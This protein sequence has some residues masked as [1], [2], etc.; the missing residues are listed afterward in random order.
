[1]AIK[2]LF[3]ASALSLLGL[4]STTAVTNSVGENQLRQSAEIPNSAVGQPNVSEIFA[5]AL[6]AAKTADRMQFTES[7]DRLQDTNAN[8]ADAAR[9][10]AM[11]FH[12]SIYE[13]SDLE[14]AVAR[15]RNWPASDRAS[16]NLEIAKLNAPTSRLG[17]FFGFDEPV[18]EPVTL[19]GRL[20][21]ADWLIENERFEEAR[22]IVTP[23][24]HRDRLS[25][26]LESEFPLRFE[27]I[28][29]EQDHQTRYLSMMARDRIRSGGRVAELAGYQGLHA[30]Y[31]A[32]I[33]NQTAADRLIA[34]LPEAQALSAPGILAMVEQ[35]RKQDEPAA[36]AE[37]AV[38]FTQ[39]EDFD[40]LN[41]TAW[42]N[43][44]RIVS[45]MLR[46]RGNV[47][48][49]FMIAELIPP[50]EPVEEVDAAFHAGWIAL[51]ELNDPQRALPH[52]EKILKVARGP[53][54]RSRGY[55]WLGRAYEEMGNQ[56]Q[57]Q[58]NYKSAVEHP[59]TFYGQAAASELDIS[60]VDALSVN[61][62][63]VD[64]AI[65]VRNPLVQAGLYLV[66]AGEERA[67]RVFFTDMAQFIQDPGLISALIAQLVERHQHFTALRLGKTALFEG[68]V[69]NAASH[70]V[71]VL[72][73]DANLSPRDLALTYAV[74]R[75]ESEFRVDARST[76]GAQGLLQL[77]PATAREV[78][79]SL[80]LP[81]STTRL[82]SD[83]DYNFTLGSAYL[84]RQL[85]AFNGSY[86]LAFVAYNA[87]PGR[88]REWVSR[89]GDPG[90]LSFRD[91]IDWV[92]QI[93]FP[94]TRGYVQKVMENYQ[95]YKARFGEIPDLEKDLT[96]GRQ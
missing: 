81:Y 24:W 74:A 1:M 31:S 30:A 32:I 9:W 14:A 51:R 91:A 19:R 67:A 47:E 42:W 71:G 94:E 6:E 46:E 36:A 87:G 13:V 21:R 48:T 75:Q 18:A 61:H 79:R 82:S 84:D 93:P 7:V 49:A 53:S 23:L 76:A 70:I 64:V 43:E 73:N 56:S 17:R 38:E 52:L 96:V 37:V 50:D 33:R 59:T 27:G 29:T 8:A 57:A 66:E 10:Y 78:A 80:E 20:L 26:E 15:F 55:Y 54:S 34:D 25:P 16:A 68:F 69:R 85:I 4:V 41:P 58:T 44:L 88:A 62:D 22:S 95:V 2:S 12:P 35:L 90:N 92:E 83:P 28:L 89:F 72:P 77:M 3:L 63:R 65:V 5:S 40:S 11:V 39:T 60:V 86:V 45:R